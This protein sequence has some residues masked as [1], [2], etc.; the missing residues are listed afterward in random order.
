M[1]I[2]EGKNRTLLRCDNIK[3]GWTE[4]AQNMFDI[5]GYPG[6]AATTDGD[7]IKL[8]S[9]RAKRQRKN[10]HG[11]M[12][13]DI[14]KAT[15]MVHDLVARAFYG[16]PLVR[17]YRVIHANGDP[18]DNRASNLIWSGAPLLEDQSATTSLE[19][20]REVERIRMERLELIELM[21]P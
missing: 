7:I 3:D 12:R 16:H 11:A 10:R 9:G 1:S 6:Y 14:G 19:I 4:P 17:G 13:V 5:P 18:S 15:R 8:R 2:G 21:Q 20:E